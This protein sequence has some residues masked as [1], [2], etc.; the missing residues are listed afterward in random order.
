MAKKGKTKNIKPMKSKPDYKQSLNYDIQ[1][2][3]KPDKIKPDKIFEGYSSQSSKKKKIKK[4]GK[5]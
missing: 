1:K 3:I 2:A 5:Y 4:K